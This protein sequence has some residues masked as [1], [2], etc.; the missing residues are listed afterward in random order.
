MPTA[1]ER[2]NL[3]KLPQSN[4]LAVFIARQMTPRMPFL[5]PES[6]KNWKNTGADTEKRKSS[7]R[8]WS[9]SQTS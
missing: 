2:F 5:A 7:Q 1:T 4:N 9:A 6:M 3:C 8:M